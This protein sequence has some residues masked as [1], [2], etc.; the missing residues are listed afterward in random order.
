MAFD[1][2][3]N[4]DWYIYVIVMFYYKLKIINF[5]SSIL[6]IA[7]G[8][9]S[10]CSRSLFLWSYVHYGG[11]GS[12]WFKKASF[13]STTVRT[14]LP[15]AFNKMNGSFVKTIVNFNIFDTAQEMSFS[16][17]ISLVDMNKST[18]TKE[19]FIF[20]TIPESNSFELNNITFQKYL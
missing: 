7:F 20:C 11:S 18:F 6:N 3:W 9:N 19:I 2:R 1:A 5:F 16:L 17:R 4:F 10:N 15:G 13:C 8:F 14:K 12:T